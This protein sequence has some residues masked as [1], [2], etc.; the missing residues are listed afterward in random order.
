MSYLN[1]SSKPEA[2]PLLTERR[3]SARISILPP[4]G[5]PIVAGFEEIPGAVE[6]RDLSAGGVG[7]TFTQPLALGA[8]V[9][10]KLLHTTRRTS[11]S[12]C[13]RVVYCRKDSEATVHLGAAFTRQLTDQELHFLELSDG[14]KG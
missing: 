12:H 5:W 2:A 9:T 6:F 3:K 8:Q 7:L 1:G 14:S 11:V 4:A 10:L 13:M